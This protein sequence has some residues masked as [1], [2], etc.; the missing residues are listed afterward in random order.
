MDHF[1]PKRRYNHGFLKIQ[2]YHRADT[3]HQNQCLPS[4]HPFPEEQAG[5]K[6]NQNRAGA[7]IDRM[8]QGRGHHTAEIDNE[9]I[10]SKAAQG[11]QAGCP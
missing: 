1:L 4:I 11:R 9:Q 3:Q 8:Q 5:S 7:V 2:E 10:G 6:G